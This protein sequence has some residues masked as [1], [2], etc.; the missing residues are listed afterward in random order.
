MD[1]ADTIAI[2]Q[3]W[4][5]SH[6]S[7][8]VFPI[9]FCVF[10]FPVFPQGYVAFTASNYRLYQNYISPYISADLSRHHKGQLIASWQACAW[11]LKEKNGSGHPP[12]LLPNTCT[13]TFHVLIYPDYPFVFLITLISLP[14]TTPPPSPPL[15]GLLPL[16]CHHTCYFSEQ[17][18]TKHIYVCTSSL[19]LCACH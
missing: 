13:Y 6:Q 8:N 15:L 7:H 1:V 5:F 19:S 17:R 11:P 4:P 3:D 16:L 10:P 9:S 12:P 18:W 14:Q 2:K